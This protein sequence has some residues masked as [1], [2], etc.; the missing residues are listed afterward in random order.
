[1]LR[2]RH[3]RVNVPYTYI[4]K[5]LHEAALEAA[6][7]LRDRLPLLHYYCYYCYYY[8]YYYY[9]YHMPGCGPSFAAHASVGLF[10]GETD[11]RLFLMYGSFTGDVGLFYG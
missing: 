11:V 3:A 9:Y 6:G 10:S 5:C 4:H 1:M 2:D 8:Y 7:M